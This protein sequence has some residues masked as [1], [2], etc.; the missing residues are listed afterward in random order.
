V[1]ETHPLDEVVAKLQAKVAERRAAGQYDDA[2]EEELAAHFRRI[3]AHRSNRGYDDL[4]EQ[5]AKVVEAS[6]FDPHISATSDVPGGAALHRLVGKLVARQTAG[7]IAQVQEFANA[8]RVALDR[9]VGALE[10]P[11]RHEH[12]DLVGQIDAIY[13][14]LASYE[15]TPGDAGVA[16]LDL[17]RRVDELTQA[18]SARR[19][20][21]WYSNDHFEEQFRGTRDDL[22]NIYRDL[23][24]RLEGYSPVV[25]IGCGRGE[26]LELLA[27]RGVLA[28]GIELDA[29][30]VEGAAA[31]GLD[32]EHGD[33][34]TY[35]AKQADASL[36]GIALIQVIEHLTP[37]QTIDLV[38]LSAEKLRPGGRMVIETV[39]PQSL[40]VYAHSFYLDPTHVRPVHPSY[41]SFLFSEAGFAHVEIDWRSPT[42]REDVLEDVAA[43]DATEKANVARL[44][45][46]LF[47]PQDYALIVTR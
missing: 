47:A 29:R 20:D 46:L 15:R 22:L 4:R 36:G 9:I 42:P 28:K 3:V 40:Y 6:Q 30:L 25:D 31:L 14:R 13:E 17:R 33:G 41:L 1:D 18:E 10:D 43:A 19:F 35:L 8:T 21:P 11:A 26:F 24:A 23:A 37:Q 27:E 44:N 12:A 38:A 32:V 16:L 34:L 45:Q 5:L 2:L 7:I 39:N